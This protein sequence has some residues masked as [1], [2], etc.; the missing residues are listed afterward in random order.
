M[1]NLSIEDLKT[2]RLALSSY[3]LSKA[4][5]TALDNIDRELAT[6][7]IKAVYKSLPKRKYQRQASGEYVFEAIKK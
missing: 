4:V 1:N 5:I 2:I 3:P 6:H 7:N